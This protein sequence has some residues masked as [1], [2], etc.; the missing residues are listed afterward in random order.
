M[1]K[2]YTALLLSLYAAAAVSYDFTPSSVE[3]N[4]WPEY[5]KAKYVYTDIGKRSPYARLV[6]P[7]TIALWKGRLGEIWWNIHHGCAGMI[8]IVR[9]ERLAGKNEQQ[10]KFA[11]NSAEN[12]ATFSVARTPASHPLHA[13][14]RAILAR[15]AYG[16]GQREAAIAELRKVL[17]SMPEVANTYSVLATYLYRQGDLDQ[18][19][20]VLERGI[21]EVPQPTA[22]MHYILG[23]ILVKKK[24]YEEAHVQAVEAYK[25][26]YPLPGLRNMLKSAGHWRG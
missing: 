4:S 23:L 7:D 12:E 18:A 20:E 10:Y 26:G 21:V 9:S 16:R 5:C 24:A 25:L 1:I 6:S 15:V 17:K 19:R 14:M 8:W 11:L 2:R 13:T 3:F 22:E